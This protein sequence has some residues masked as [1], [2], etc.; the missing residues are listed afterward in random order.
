MATVQE[1]IKVGKLIES[2]SEGRD[3]VHIA[4]AP[5]L[6]THRLHA[7]DHVSADG[8][9]S[10]P[11]VGIA[12]PFLTDPIERGQRFWI[13]LYPRAVTSLRHVWSHPAFADEAG[14]MLVSVQDKSASEKWMRAWALK[15]MSEDYYGE[16]GRLTDDTAYNNAIHAGENNH[17]GPYE[18]ARE[19]IDEEW[20]N[21]WEAITGRKGKR[22]EYFSCSC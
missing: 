6:A 8:T 3:A 17:V 9:H 11:H 14:A 13:F 21:H 15:H 1:S 16:A 19:H 12:D 2:E 20:W 18:D 5:A 22:D 7:G 4:I 10:H